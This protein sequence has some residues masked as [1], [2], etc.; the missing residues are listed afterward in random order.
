MYI[1]ITF[2]IYFFADSDTNNQNLTI[3]DL[4]QQETEAHDEDQKPV[5]SKIKS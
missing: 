5:V 2:R 3:D 1:R 4:H